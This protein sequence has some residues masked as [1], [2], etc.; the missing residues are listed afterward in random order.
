M[1]HPP[2]YDGPWPNEKQ[3]IREKADTALLLPKP[4]AIK[5]VCTFHLTHPAYT[6]SKG[7]HHPVSIYKIKRATLAQF[8]EL[9]RATFHKL[10]TAPAAARPAPSSLPRRPLPPPSTRPTGK[11]PG[12]SSSSTPRG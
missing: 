2:L 1:G 8:Y 3:P 9:A 12:R 7:I 5:A 10:F 11:S 6:D 4:L